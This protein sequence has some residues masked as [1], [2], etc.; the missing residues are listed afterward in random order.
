MRRV[1][2]TRPAWWKIVAVAFG[3]AL[4]AVACASGGGTS[5][6]GATP[7]GGSSSSSPL[8]SGALCQDAAA[9]RTSLASLTHIKVGTGAG[10]SISSGVADVKA[11]LATFTAD[12]GQQ[13]HAQTAALN[14][15]LGKLGTQAKN[16]ASQPSAAALDGVVNALGDVTTAAQN[17]LGAVNTRCPSASPST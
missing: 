14:S 4:L 8:P 6:G 9:L 12:A 10:A 15:A 16:L 3:V 1:T 17:L 5:S 13:W 11:K 7:A 2:V